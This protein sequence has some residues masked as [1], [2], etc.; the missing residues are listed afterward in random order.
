VSAARRASGSLK[1]QPYLPGCEFA[2]FVSGGSMSGS[3]GVAPGG[4]VPPPSNTY[5][6]RSRRYSAAL[7]STL[8]DCPL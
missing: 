7:G 4:G 6:V 1:L 3:I 8:S 2:A 5:R